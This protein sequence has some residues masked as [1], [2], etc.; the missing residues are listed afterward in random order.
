MLCLRVDGSER[1]PGGKVRHIGVHN[2]S[3]YHLVAKVLS[4]YQFRIGL[5][6][7]LC[8]K[9]LHG[10]VVGSGGRV[11]VDIAFQIILSHCLKGGFHFFRFKYVLNRKG[12]VAVLDSHRVLD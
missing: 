11:L 4:P 7:S 12:F 1:A 6:V 10:F 5:A 3:G 8:H 9:T 2:R